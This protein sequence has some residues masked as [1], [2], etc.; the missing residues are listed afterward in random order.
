MV[1]VIYFIYFSIFSL[2]GWIFEM[3]FR[4]IKEERFVNSGCLFGPFVPIYGYTAT[5]ILLFDNYFI[6]I[7]LIF[8]IILFC[9]APT[10]FEYIGSYLLEKQFS[11]HLWDYSHVKHN[12][13]G[14]I[15][16]F[17]SSIW[18]VLIIFI[19]F[20]IQPFLYKFIINVKPQQLVIISL[21]LLIY[22]SL[23]T[24]ITIKTFNK[25]K[26]VISMIKQQV[27][28]NNLQ[29]V[30]YNGYKLL[31]SLIRPILAFPAISKIILKNLYLNNF[32]S[33]KLIQQ[34]EQ[35]IEYMSYIS[36]IENN[37]TFLQLKNFHH[38]LNSIYIHSKKVSYIS[39]KIGKML[40]KYFKVNLIELARGSLLHDF[41]LYEWRKE[42]L[43]M[44]KQHAFE[45]PKEAYRNSSKYISNITEIEKDIILKHMW[46]LSLRSPK[47]LETLIVILVDKLIASDE[48]FIEFVSK[49]PRPV[50]M[51]PEKKT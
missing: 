8:R 6:V 5:T 41:F 46:P 18:A 48:F 3:A 49:K 45:H 36:D 24:I 13:H 33:D 17:F 50:I 43:P 47:Y 44:G 26:I 38:H 20:V 40:N 51:S 16:L 15:C 22:F 25:V 21:V 12:L 32:N 2:L 23:D 27:I 14:R 31:N 35:D 39:Y 19:Y 11:I 37:L 30:K 29:C 4:S 9:L 28:S 7:P 10:V 42:I 34:S 1:V